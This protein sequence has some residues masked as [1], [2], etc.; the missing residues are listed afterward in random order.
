MQLE[1][2]KYLQEISNPFLDTF[3]TLIT[4]L[5]SETFY[6]LAITYIY[7][8]F[9]KNLGIRLLFITMSSLYINEIL[10]ELF[11]TQRPIH[12]EGINTVLKKPLSRYSFPS[13]NA[14]VAA[15]FWTYLMKKVKDKKVYI[16]GCT[17]VILV[18]FS[19]VYLR[20]HW[21]IDVIGGI[22][23]AIGIVVLMDYIINKV[24]KYNMADIMKIA[25]CILISMILLLL[26]FDETTA[27][28]VGLTVA[29]LIGYFIENRHINFKEKADLKYQIAKYIIGVLVFLALKIIIKKA[30][31]S[32][33]VFSY[34]RYF[35]LGL[36]ITLLAP[37][38]FVK[39]G[40]SSKSNN[41]EKSILKA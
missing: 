15:A 26:K 28:I 40:L 19:R 29:A 31:P 5:G 8:C 10:K 2:L 6:I 3:F 20:V 12:V 24:D 35:V 11:H 18:A 38:L 23:I 7:W 14:Q 22:L 30:L 1:F 21:P 37:A 25:V 32:G 34:V 13:G 33:V 17:I 41:M 36:W 9:N 4:N 27:K 16:I 39:T